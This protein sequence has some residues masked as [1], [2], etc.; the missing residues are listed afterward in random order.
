MRINNSFFGFCCIA[1]PDGKYAGTSFKTTTLAW[2]SRNSRSDVKN[3][4]ID[5]YRHNLKEYANVL[6]YCRTKNILV[7]RISSNLF[8]LADHPDWSWVF[9]DFEFDYAWNS[10]IL[11]T[12]NFLSFGAKLST[13]PGQFVSITSRN[14]ETV[15]NS[16][17]SLNFHARFMD[18]LGLPGDHRAH[19]NIHLSNGTKCPKES[20]IIATDALAHLDRSALNRLTFENED[21][22]CWQVS[23]IKGLFPAFPIVFDS[24]HYN[25]NPDKFLNFS[26]A[27][28]SATESWSA[29]C[30]FQIRP[31]VHYS[32]G[33]RDRTDRT[34]RKHS[35]YINVFKLPPAYSLVPVFCEIEAKKKNLAVNKA[36]DDYS[37]HTFKR[38]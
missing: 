8:P 15:K 28:H 37:D 38:I 36:K 24:H 14:S 32:E 29:N 1:L 27:F 17:K 35:D 7:Y 10:A 6:S 2:C 3:K 30:K 23:T 25:C 21:G 26:E 11:A 31:T 4:L 33:A 22:G 16:I 9:D 12:R 5:I 18:L 19:I 34:D 20:K 13:H